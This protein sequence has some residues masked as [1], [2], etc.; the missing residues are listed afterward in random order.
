LLNKQEEEARLNKLIEQSDSVV[1]IYGRT[2]A[3]PRT[4][5]DMPDGDIN[6]CILASSGNWFCDKNKD[7]GIEF[8]SENVG[9]GKPRNVFTGMEYGI[10]E[11]RHI[12]RIDRNDLKRLFDRVSPKASAV[13]QEEGE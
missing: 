3:N 9:N 8:L 12:N 4:G 10:D 6:V 13:A 11:I 2:K 5:K 7:V 1:Y